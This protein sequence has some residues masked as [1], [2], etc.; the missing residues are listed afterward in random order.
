VVTTF[1]QLG[2][3]LFNNHHRSLRRLH[4]LAGAVVIL[5]EV[6]NLPVR[7]WPLFRRMLGAAA[8]LL[9][10]RWILM[11][12]TQPAIFDS[13]EGAVELAGD[14]GAFFEG[15]RRVELINELDEPMTVAQLAERIG[16]EAADKRVLVVVNTIRCALELHSLLQENLDSKLMFLSSEVIPKHRLSRIS[17]MKDDKKKT[18]PL[19]CVS[20]QLIEAGVDLDFDVVYRD[21]APLDSVVQAAGRCNRG[22]DESKT[23]RVVLIKLV[24]EDDPGKYYSNYVYDSVL[25]NKAEAV[26]NPGVIREAELQKLVE[27]YFTEI[28]QSVTGKPSRTLL[29]LARSHKHGTLAREFKLIDDKYAKVDLFVI[30]DNEAAAVWEEYQSVREMHGLPRIR[31]MRGLKPRMAPYIISV[32]LRSLQQCFPDAQSGELIPIHPEHLEHLYDVE[33]GFKRG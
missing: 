17:E 25:L 32:S 16:A 6:Q 22:G 13:E 8:E 28:S 10:T 2:L 21:R 33:T 24:P 31:S 30:V 20:T 12:A 1:V 18:E 9:G 29:D 5:D 7:Y 14:P 23:G 4:R 26:L 3:T 19:I 11:T 15:L 27:A